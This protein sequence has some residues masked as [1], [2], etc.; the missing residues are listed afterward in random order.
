MKNQKRILLI[1]SDR[2]SRRA[3]HG[4][5]LA[6]NFDVTDSEDVEQAI[7][8][9]RIYR[10]DLVMV[11]LSG[12][13]NA[14]SG[15]R[16][17]QLLCGFPGAALVALTDSGNSDR[18]AEMLENGADECIVKPFYLPELAARLRALIRR[19]P[20]SQTFSTGPIQ[21]GDFRLEPEQYTVYKSGVPVRLNPKE[22]TLLQLL[23][24]NAGRPVPHETLLKALKGS[25][26]TGRV[27]YLRMLVRQLRA[28]LNDVTH[29]QYLL[30]DSCVGYRFADKPDAA[31]WRHSGCAA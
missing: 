10:F 8:L 27:E 17:Y 6:A 23:M 29:P 9:G 22:L 16:L 1:D 4:D 30:T 20:N 7:A 26:Y 18:T 19:L 24:S 2:G 12:L 28:K 13:S 3:L 11:D 21:V 31:S 5:L 25:E 14:G 15:A